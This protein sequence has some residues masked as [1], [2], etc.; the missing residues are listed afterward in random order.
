MHHHLDDHS[1]DDHTSKEGLMH[2]HPTITESTIT[3]AAG[4][5]ARWRLHH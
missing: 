3:R 1:V 4:A 2:H 5:A